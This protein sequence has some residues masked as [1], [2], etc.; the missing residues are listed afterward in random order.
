MKQIHRILICLFYLA[1][2][3]TSCKIKNNF[4]QIIIFFFSGKKKI[5]K[6]N[7]FENFF[8]LFKFLLLL[9]W[10]CLQDPS[11]WNKIS[12]RNPFFFFSLLAWQIECWSLRCQDPIALHTDPN[13]GDQNVSSFN[14]FFPF[15][16]SLCFAISV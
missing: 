4:H 9:F 8:S 16:C 6:G 12:R 13:Q 10:P 7:E 1:V 3:S 2:S 14:S 5:N 11:K 15:F